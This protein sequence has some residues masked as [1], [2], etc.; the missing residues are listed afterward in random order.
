MPAPTPRSELVLPPLSP[1]LVGRPY[2]AIPHLAAYAQQR[3]STGI[4]QTDLNQ[5]YVGHLLRSADPADL[6]TSADPAS[7]T[8]AVDDAIVAAIL[9]AIERVPDDVELLAAA[10]RDP[11]MREWLFDRVGLAESE[12]PEDLDAAFAM[13][14]LLRD[15]RA[16]FAD[17]YR[18][19]GVPRLVGVSVPFATQLAPALVLAEV[20]REL[21]DDVFVVLGG[22]LPSLLSDEQVERL[23]RNSAVSA[24]VR[25]EGEEAFRLLHEADDLS[26]AGISGIPSLSYRD[27]TAVTVKRPGEFLVRLTD[28][29]PYP[30]DPEYVA[31]GVELPVIVGRGCFYT[32]AFCDYI[33]LYERINFRSPADVVESVRLAAAQSRTGMLHFVYEVMS[34]RYERKLVRALV[35]AD[36]GIQWRGFQ[37]VYGEMTADDVRMLEASG[38]RRL[39]IGLESADDAALQRMDKGYTRD[40]IAAFLRAFEGTS[41]QL[42]VNVIVD[43]PGLTYERA[44]EAAR[45]LAEAT[46]K[47]DSLHF[48]VLRFALGRN[49]AM[50]D[51]PDDFGL[52]ILPTSTNGSPR[53]TSPTQVPFSSRESMSPEERARVEAYYR[54]LNGRNSARRAERAASDLRTADERWVSREPL[55]YTTAV[56]SADI[57]VRRLTTAETFLLSRRY[58]PLIQE[59]CRRTA[60]TRLDEL[61]AGA[62]RRR[63]GLEPDECAEVLE[64]IG[65]LRPDPPRR[66]RREP[67]RVGMATDGDFFRG[68]KRTGEGRAI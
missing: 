28:T 16:F 45:F 1:V 24:V 23:L 17:R 29:A 55:V 59:V 43:Y 32:C 42:L 65:L 53:P 52:T 27:G 3:G 30:L 13:V 57:A 33:Q 10:A 26:P 5:A 31:E 60:A 20:L 15:M 9:A 49:S 46:E 8:G 2:A 11:G 4:R 34:V 36:L 61:V 12:S 18:V 68:V 58:E 39:D 14:P 50:F 7:L 37:R 62:W 54:T 38:C 6:P 67:V 63:V 19:R 35:E 41:I 21:A 51:R 40:D 22:P 66:P 56:D 64:G 25:H 48:E 47:I 44:M